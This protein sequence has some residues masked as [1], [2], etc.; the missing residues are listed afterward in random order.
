MQQFNPQMVQEIL[1]SMESEEGMRAVAKKLA[2]KSS[3]PSLQGMAALTKQGVPGVR[4]APG[5]QPQ[6]ESLG[7]LLSGSK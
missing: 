5:V 4:P 2:M 3:P 6:N 7:G 1:G